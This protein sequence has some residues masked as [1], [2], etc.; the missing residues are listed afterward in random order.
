MEGGAA[1]QDV[2]DGADRL[3]RGEAMFTCGRTPPV[4]L[5]SSQETA[6][7][8]LGDTWGHLRTLTLLSAGVDLDHDL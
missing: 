4:S 8:P 3:L 6:Q 2:L 1:G 7:R 5:L